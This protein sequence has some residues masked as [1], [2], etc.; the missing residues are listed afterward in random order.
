MLT[1]RQMACFEN[2][3]QFLNEVAAALLKIAA[4]MTAD[5][6][7][8]KN[9]PASTDVEKVFAE[10]RE[11]IAAQILAEQGISFQTTAL[12]SATPSAAGGSKAMSY[13]VRQMLM[14]STWTLTPDAWAADEPAAATEITTRMSELIQTLT[15]IPQVQP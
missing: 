4:S 2:N 7:V 14:M 10:K 11:Q 12:P 6:L 9:T 13:L 8:V 15:A 3:K 1:Q 5:A